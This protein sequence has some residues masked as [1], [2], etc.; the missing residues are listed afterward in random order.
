MTEYLSHGVFNSA[1]G[2]LLARSDQRRSARL[3][4]RPSV[5]GWPVEMREEALR[6][7]RAERQ[8]REHAAFVGPRGVGALLA[9][10]TSGRHGFHELPT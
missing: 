9:V 7:R 8:G 4:K 6:L 1:A 2:P 10:T 5:Q 3:P